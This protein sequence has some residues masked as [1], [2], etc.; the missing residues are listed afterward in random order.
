[1]RWCS[2][3]HAG[4]DLC[5]QAVPDGRVHYTLNVNDWRSWPLSAVMIAQGGH[6]VCID[7][8][9]R[10]VLCCDEKGQVLPAAALAQTHELLCSALEVPMVQRAITRVFRDKLARGQLPAVMPPPRQAMAVVPDRVRARGGR[11]EVFFRADALLPEG[12]L[13]C[14]GCLRDRDGI[15]IDEGQRGI[16][17]YGPYMD[18]SPGRYRATFVFAFGANKQPLRMDVLSRQHLGIQRADLSGLA[19]GRVASMV[20]DLDHEA[21]GLEVRLHSE[22]GFAGRCLGLHLALLSTADVAPR[23]GGD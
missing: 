1:M 19:P 6:R 18:L 10:D 8:Q 23:G 21:T 15:Y 7:Y 22:E 16:L 3:R 5:R 2:R 12:Q 17:I 4:Y 13:H 20:F 11:F 14:G 9:R